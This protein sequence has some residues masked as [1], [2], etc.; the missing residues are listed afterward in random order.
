[1]TRAVRLLVWKELEP[2]DLRKTH[3][4]SSDAGTGGG[5]RDLRFRPYA[6]F[7]PLFA[8]LFPTV[9]VLRERP[10]RVGTVKWFEGEAERSARAEFWPPTDA[11]PTEGRWSK[12]HTLPPLQAD[13]PEDEGRLVLLLVQDDTGDVWLRVETEAELRRPG[14]NPDVVGPLLATLDA[15]AGQGWLDFAGGT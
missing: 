9:E 14:W 1:M 6:A 5:A 13:F 8:R 3:A 7:G 12:I 2:G 10:V 11:R 15:G 4:A